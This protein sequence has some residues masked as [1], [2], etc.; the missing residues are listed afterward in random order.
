MT[1]SFIVILLSNFE[2]RVTASEELAVNSF[3]RRLAMYTFIDPE[4]Q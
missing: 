2:V 3:T 1:V 4:S